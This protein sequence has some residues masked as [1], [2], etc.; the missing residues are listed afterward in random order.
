MHFNVTD[1]TAGSVHCNL[2][3]TSATGLLDACLCIL[4]LLNRTLG[5]LYV[6]QVGLEVLVPWKWPLSG[7]GLSLT[8]LTMPGSSLEQCQRLMDQVN[9][10][11][12]LTS[13]DL[14]DF[15][16]GVSA[17]LDQL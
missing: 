6:L 15:I 1:V 7:A 3:H 17:E 14:A 5:P 16:S 10:N 9:S 2:V 8:A 11:S 12:S 4:M 13:R